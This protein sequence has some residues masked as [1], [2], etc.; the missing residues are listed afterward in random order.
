MFHHEQDFTSFPLTGFPPA[1]QEIAF[2][3]AELGMHVYTI[4]VENQTTRDPLLIIDPS[5]RR[6]WKRRQPAYPVERFFDEYFLPE[7]RKRYGA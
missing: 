7:I 3:L 2:V 4:N 5:I 1:G 6:T